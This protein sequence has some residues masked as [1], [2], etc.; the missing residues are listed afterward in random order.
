MEGIIE[1]FCKD[2]KFVQFSRFFMP[3]S[4]YSDLNS[5]DGDLFPYTQENVQHA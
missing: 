3:F 4:Y 1:K 2:K 5:E